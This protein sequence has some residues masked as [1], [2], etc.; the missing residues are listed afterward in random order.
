[1][2]KGIIKVT[3]VNIGWGIFVIGSLALILN[4]NFIKSKIMIFL[5]I[6]DVHGDFIEKDQKTILR[7]FAHIA[8]DGLS[9]IEIIDIKIEISKKKLFAF[10]EGNIIK[11]NDNDVITVSPNFFNFSNKTPN[12]SPFII[13]LTPNKKNLIIRGSFLSTDHIFEKN[14]A[15]D[16]ILTVIIG[17]NKSQR[18]FTINPFCTVVKKKYKFKFQPTENF[19]IIPGEVIIPMDKIK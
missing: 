8:N 10:L 17:P 7:L 18:L 3:T 11:E 14:T 6:K 9:S 2:I 16:A 15:I 19:R 12:L 1:M 5:K 4:Y 13:M